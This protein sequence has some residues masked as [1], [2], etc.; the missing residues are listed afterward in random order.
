MER[1][2]KT[3]MELDDIANS[4]LIFPKSLFDILLKQENPTELIALYSF[5]YYTAK[6]QRTNQIKATNQFCQNG[7]KMG[8]RTF[9]KAKKTLLKLGLIEK[10]KYSNS[11]DQG[12]YIKVK[13]IKRQDL[14]ETT[15]EPEEQGSCSDTKNSGKQDLDSSSPNALSS[16]NINALSSNSKKRD[17]KVSLKK[18]KLSKRHF[19]TFWKAYPRKK[20][21]QNA[22]KAWDKILALSKDKQPS[23]KTILEAITEQCKQEQ[24]QTIRFIPHPATWLNAH[25]WEDEVDPDECISIK[26]KNNLGTHNFKSNI[27]QKFTEGREIDN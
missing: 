17:T 25:R 14:L 18:K 21:K 22:V 2:Q 8:E 26:R 19:D 16:V 13:Y 10:L 15:Q 12:W 24:W 1:K 5:Y 11:K 9:L 3:E 4:L 27:R 23:I 20:E 7:L 6:W